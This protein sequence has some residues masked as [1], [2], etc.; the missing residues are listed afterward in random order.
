MP[1]HNGSGLHSSLDMLI[2]T[3][4]QQMLLYMLNNFIL[5]HPLARSQNQEQNAVKLARDFLCWNSINGVY[6][7]FYNFISVYNRFKR[8]IGHELRFLEGL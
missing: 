2:V 6:K 1:I 5:P 7:W 8:F 3:F 4:P